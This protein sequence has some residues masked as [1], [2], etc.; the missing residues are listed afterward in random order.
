M[1]DSF[2]KTNTRENR[3]QLSITF[4]KTTLVLFVREKIQSQLSHISSY[5]MEN[6]L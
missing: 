1:Q 5:I 3:K 6:K 4:K 2:L